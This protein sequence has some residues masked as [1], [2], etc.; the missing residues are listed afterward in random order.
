MADSAREQLIDIAV[1]AFSEAW[2]KAMEG[3][4]DTPYAP[5][6]IDAILA[7]P[8]VVLRALGGERRSGP[9]YSDGRFVESWWIP[10]TTEPREN[11]NG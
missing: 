9:A 3:Q 2:E 10:T 1:T 4:G 11:A 5:A 8:D 7:N 6:I